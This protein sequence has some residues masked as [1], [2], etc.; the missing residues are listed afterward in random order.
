M[1]EQMFNELKN[2]TN[3]QN[4]IKTLEGER[5]PIKEF[6]KKFVTKNE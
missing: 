5:S 2:Q 1:N 6:I 4:L 3:L